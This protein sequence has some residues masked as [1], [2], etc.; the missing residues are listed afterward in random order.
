MLHVK[1]KF[2]VIYEQRSL[3]FSTSFDHHLFQD[4]C[5]ILASPV[6]LTVYTDSGFADHKYCFNQV[7]LHRRT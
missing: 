1:Q 5:Q 7:L 3:R 2:Q 6:G 4:G